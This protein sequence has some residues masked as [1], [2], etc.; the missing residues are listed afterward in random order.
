VLHALMFD[1]LNFATGRLDPSYVA[2]A[3]KANVC[4][5]TVATALARLRE[6][7]IL[8]WV[9]APRAGAMAASC[10]S[11]RPTP[12]PCCLRASGGATERQ[13]SRRRPQQARGE[14]PARM[15]GTLAVAASEG[16]HGAGL[17]SAVHA[18]EAELAAALASLGRAFM[19]KTADFTGLHGMRRNIPQG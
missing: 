1:F 6:L 15:P 4:E 11:R 16:Q 18:L 5:R 10:W 2:I 17:R 3:R 19:A 14:K 7:G 12:T 13:Q 9:P 8:H